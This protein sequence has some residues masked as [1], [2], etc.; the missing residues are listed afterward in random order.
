MYFW[1]NN[2]KEFKQKL[3]NN[4]E[5][6]PF[7]YKN[8]SLLHSY[9]KPRTL[10]SFLR[11]NEGNLHKLLMVYLN[12][13]NLA[14]P[15]NPELFATGQFNYIFDKFKEGATF[16]I[17]DLEKKNETIAQICQSFE[18]I[19]GGKSWS[20]A[21][22]TP[23]NCKGLSVHF[24]ITSIVVVQ[25]EGTKKWKV[26]DQH[27]K[28]PNLSMSKR[29][30][31]KDL[32]EPLFEA[33]LE[34]GDIL[35]LP[36]GFPHSA[37][38][39]GTQSIHLGFAIDP[40]DYLDVLIYGLKEKAKKSYYLRE[41][42]LNEAIKDKNVLDISK[43]FEDLNPN[44]L[45]STLKRY[46]IS[47]NANNVD[48]VHN[49][50]SSLSYIDNDSVQFRKHPDKN[51]D[52]IINNTGI[53]IYLPNQIIPEKPALVGEPSFLP[54]P[55]ECEKTI[56]FVLS[57]EAFKISDMPDNLDQNTNINLINLLISHSILTSVENESV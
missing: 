9:I 14:I 17:E 20:K 12:G 53:K 42:I 8:A 22:W 27:I 16:K 18:N 37:Q 43:L 26:W 34:P 24:D 1:I 51:I 5:K 30:F 38:S 35:Y 41:S 25:L 48:F 52:L 49:S 19:F 4:F 29:V 21:F 46:N 2:N 10:E 40:V 3:D 33:T 23:K 45:L 6:K 36:A 55:I 57:G 7:I 15:A 50:L 11:N 44:D 31:E 28:K 32:G 54:L 56:K 39:L 47:K 13:E